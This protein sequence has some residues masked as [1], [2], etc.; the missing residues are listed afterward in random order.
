MGKGSP[1]KPFFTANDIHKLYTGS[2]PIY[3]LGQEE[4]QPTCS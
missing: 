3:V 4:K 2:A 1:L